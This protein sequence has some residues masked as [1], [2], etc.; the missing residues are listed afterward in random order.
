M[1][2]DYEKRLDDQVDASL[3]RRMNRRQAK[4][5]PH[6]VELPVRRRGKGKIKTSQLRGL[7]KRI[8]G[9]E[10]LGNL[11]GLAEGAT[12]MQ[13][14]VL[15]WVGFRAGVEL[16]QIS[17]VGKDAVLAVRKCVTAPDPASAYTDPSR[18]YAVLV[19]GSDRKLRFLPS[20]FGVMPFVTLDKEAAIGTRK[21]L[22]EKG[23]KEAR[24]VR[25]WFCQ[26]IFDEN[27][28]NAGDPRLAHAF[29]DDE[30]TTGEAEE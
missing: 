27:G 18:G 13:R 19:R 4:R 14:A 11:S 1:S 6:M 29:P 16:A 30:V 10:V 12:M 9:P 20:G 2:K 28:M 15:G 23:I 24:V 22:N 17:E 8:L 21:A 3:L 25:V 26:P 5:D 7:Y